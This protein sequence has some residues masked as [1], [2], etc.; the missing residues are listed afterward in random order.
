MYLDV[1]IHKNR[2]G[3]ISSSLFRKSTVGNSIF[4]VTSFHHRSLVSS[5]PYS[6][7]LRICWNCSDETTCPLTISI[8][9]PFTSTQNPIHTH[10]IIPF[11]FMFSF[12]FFLVLFFFYSIHIE[13]VLH[14]FVPWCSIQFDFIVTALTAFP[15]F[16]HRSRLPACVPARRT[17]AIYCLFPAEE[18]GAACTLAGIVSARLHRG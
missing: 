6:Q 11:L 12:N 10:S 2:D 3:S 18:V 8:S 16:V 15:P 17:K 4:H 7:Y 5:I 13:N 9:V 1:E 14:M